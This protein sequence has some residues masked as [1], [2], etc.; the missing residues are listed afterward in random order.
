MAPP[1]KILIANRGE[2]SCRAQRACEKL[3]IGAVAVYAEPDALS[4]HVLRAPESVCL[5]ASSKAYLD[6]ARLLQVAKETGCQAVFPGYG[7]LSENTEFAEMCEASGIAFVGPTAATMAMFAQKH[8]ARALAEAAQVPVLPGSGLLKNEEEA[9]A[10]AIKIGL[11]VLLKATGGGGGIGIHTCRTEEEVRTNFGSAA[12]QGAAAFGDA[13][14]F[15]EKF[16]ERARHIEV[17]IFGDGTGKVVAFPERECSIQRRHQKIL[18]ET[19]S[20]FVGPELRA[21][22]QGAALRLG[23]QAKY[24]SAGTVEFIVDDAT[25]AF[26]FLEVNTRLQVEHG[27]TEMVAGVDL[28]AMQFELAGAP[29]QG[30]L[31]D[32]LEALELGINGAAIEV[33]ICA[34]DPAHGYRPCTGELAAC[35]L[36]FFSLHG[37]SIKRRALSTA[38]QGGSALAAAV[39][40]GAYL[41]SSL[42]LAPS[43]PL[44]TD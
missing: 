27:I 13:G 10:H 38:A 42:P 20:P 33:R 17:Q 21:A 3:G 5:G 36:S 14:V 16:V 1:F 4:L 39:P 19:P 40:A 8:T 37:S 34:E 15:V 28:V 24:R 6:A 26:Y 22:L 30:N 7:F 31:P 2:I 29:K 9:V 23:R 32:D 43:P 41:N 35:C 18:E 25:G 44:F 12:R 11:P